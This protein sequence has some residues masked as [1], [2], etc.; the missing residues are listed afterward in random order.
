MELCNKQSESDVFRTRVMALTALSYRF[1]PVTEGEKKLNAH[2]IVPSRLVY[3]AQ[4]T[5]KCSQ[6][7][8]VCPCVEF[9]IVFT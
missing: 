1:S 6:N 5:S 4:Y 8:S 7:H 3:C 2:S 9:V